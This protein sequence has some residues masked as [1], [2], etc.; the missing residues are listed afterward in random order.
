LGYFLLS[1]GFG[2]S[3]KSHL[4]KAW[5]PVCGATGAWWN[6]Q[7]VGPRRKEVIGSMPLKGTLRPWPSSLT[8][9]LWGE[10]CPPTGGPAITYCFG[11]G[12][13]QQVKG[14]QTEISQ[15]INE[16]TTFLF[17]RWFSQVFWHSNRK[18]SDPILSHGY[19]TC[20]EFFPVYNLNLTV[21]QVPRD[22]LTLNLP[23][24]K[25]I[26]LPLSVLHLLR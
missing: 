11:T 26:L 20:A 21:P 25:L 8:L 1:F 12:P 7:E 6:L 19:H 2:Q 15:N 3:P 17:T 5:C 14:L 23:K 10:Q 9:P 18:L 22:S 24:T 16:N 13:K 4:L